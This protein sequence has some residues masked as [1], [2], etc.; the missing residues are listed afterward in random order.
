MIDRGL[1]AQYVKDGAAPIYYLAG[2]PGM[3][4]ALQAMLKNVGVKDA[5][6]RAEEFAGY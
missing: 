1:L 4:G 2:P 6:I 5:D 3:V